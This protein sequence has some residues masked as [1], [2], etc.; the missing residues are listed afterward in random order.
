MRKIDVWGNGWV[1]RWYQLQVLQD[2][3]EGIKNRFYLLWHRRAGKDWTAWRAMVEAAIKRKQNYTYYFPTGTLGRQVIFEGI[4]AG[5]RGYLSD[6]P[7]ELIKG[8]RQDDMN[9]TLANGST[10]RIQGTDRL[11]VVGPN[12]FGVV[13]SEYAKQNPLA[14]TYVRPILAANGGWAIFTTTPRSRN[15]GWSLWKD[16]ENEKTWCRSKLTVAMTGV[17]SMEEVQ[18]DL[19]TG[20][21]LQYVLQEYFCSFDA[22]LEDAALAA[23]V[24]G[25]RSSGRLTTIKPVAD[26]PILA[27]WDLGYD[28]YMSVWAFQYVD[29]QVLIL[30]HYQDKRQRL[31]THIAAIDELCPGISTYVVPWDAQK[32]DLDGITLK[33][34]LMMAGR[35]VL[36]VPRTKSLTD[37]LE[38]VREIFPKIWMDNEK[39]AMGLSH[40]ESYNPDL[41]GQRSTKAH[42]KAH[43]HAYDALRT[44][45]RGIQLGIIKQGSA[46]SGEQEDRN[47][48]SWGGRIKIA[49]AVKQGSRH[50]AIAKVR[51]GRIG[52]YSR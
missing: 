43:S 51:A 17:I 38:N 47:D 39:C 33:E 41:H 9:I 6:L 16:T 52:R 34:K 19:R 25:L 42:G 35:K 22:G 10:I 11:D 20:M 23:D 14:W 30:A 4:D 26:V 50:H 18:R 13:F 45:V 7:N 8:V 37:D 15:H 2:F 32:H 5:G 1:P 24:Q 31:T 29:D 48:G 27:A 49:P 3:T 28:D 36:V 12:P 21:S 44:L 46:E 40:L